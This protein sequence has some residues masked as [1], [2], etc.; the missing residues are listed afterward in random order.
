MTFDFEN[1]FFHLSSW[2]LTVF[3]VITLHPPTF[4]LLAITKNVGLVFR[5]AEAATTTERI[6]SKR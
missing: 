3:T 1:S 4:T 2:K 5:L 6:T